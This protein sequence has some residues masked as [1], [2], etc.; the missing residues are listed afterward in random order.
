M[1]LR[2]D[3]VQARIVFL[4]LSEALE[5]LCHSTGPALS[6]TDIRSIAGKLG[7]YSEA[8]QSGRGG[9]FFDTEPLCL[10]VHFELSSKIPSGGSK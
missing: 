3:P 6:K 7:W 4:L 2:F 10:P 1:K 9:S 8:L 5:S